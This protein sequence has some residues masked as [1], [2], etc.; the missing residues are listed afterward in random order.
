VRAIKAAPRCNCR[1]ITATGPPPTS[2]A[3]SAVLAH[4]EQGLEIYATHDFTNHASFY[5]N[6]D[7]KVCAHGELAQVFWM[8]GRTRAALE[9]ERL[10]MEWA[11]KLAHLGS[12]VHARDMRLLHHMYRREFAVVLHEATEFVAFTTEHGLADHRAKGRIFRGWAL[13]M[14]GDAAAGL[15]I[16]EDALEDEREI[17]GLEDFPV[18]MALWAEVLM[19]A[20]QPDRAIEELARARGEFDAIGLSFWMPEL[21]RLQGEAVMADSPPAASS[22][23]SAL[24]LFESAMELAES[25]EAWMLRLRAAVSAACTHRLCGRD[26]IGGDLVRNALAVVNLD[27][28]DQ[29][30][31]DANRLLSRLR[32]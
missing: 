29:D 31:I 5:G 17:A 14:M 30:L 3:T 21:I 1:P 27:S 32:T 11:A 7:P 23:A 6:H 16:L 15:P 25:Q 12:L 19:A 24:T 9:H 2:W 13:A 22:A 18:Y 10:C 8:Q 20:G 28:D 26:Q 4:A